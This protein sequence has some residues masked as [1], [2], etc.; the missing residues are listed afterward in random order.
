V[1]LAQLAQR[2]VE[3]EDLPMTRWGK[4]TS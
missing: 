3:Q 1:G 2:V 4:K